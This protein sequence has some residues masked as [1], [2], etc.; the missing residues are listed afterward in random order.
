M[1]LLYEIIQFIIYTGLIV[2]ISKYV[3]VKTLRNLAEN[4]KLKPKAVGNIAGIATS[5]PELLTICV[6]SYSG[7]MSA[8]IYN[9]LSSNVINLIQYYGAI[10]LNKNQKYLKN[11]AIKV[12]LFLVILTI[13]LPIIFIGVKSELQILMVPVLIFLY[14]GFRKIDNNAH[15]IYLKHQDK[16]IEEIQNKEDR[17]ER[18][19]KR[20][21]V[22]NTLILLLTGILLFIIGN[23]LGD[24][25]ENL[26]LRFN[27]P[28]LV[29]GII[30]GIVTSIPE[31][32]TFFE[33]QKHYSKNKDDILG[34]VE[35]TNNL[36]TSN[37]MNLFIIQ[38]AG[39]IVFA[40]F[41][42]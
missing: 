1:E 29:I 2:L 26:C 6:S 10:I 20:K 36:L 22:K 19:N 17:W 18:G 34:V 16:E 31:L 23:S 14:L 13:I 21:I 5:V 8:S 33:S 32:I 39:I 9:V 41:H 7:L 27:V 24:T 30:L 42:G 28:Q 4:L 12:E 3:L 37:M 15:K 11:N 40:I 35:A 25:L 38:S